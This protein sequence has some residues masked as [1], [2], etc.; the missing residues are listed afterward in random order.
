MTNTP[1]LVRE[2]A[3]VISR[4]KNINKKELDFIEKFLIKLERF[5]N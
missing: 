5:M 2:A 4:N 3:F 1:A